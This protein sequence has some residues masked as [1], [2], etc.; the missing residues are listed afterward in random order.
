MRGAPSW[1]VPVLL[2]ASLA[3]PSHAAPLTLERIMADPDWI[4]PP[5]ERPFWSLDGG[6]VL[7]SLK[8]AGSPVRELW[9]APA[10]GG[11]SRRVGPTELAGLDAAQPVF[12]RTRQR[13]AFLRNGDVFV[14]DLKTR[15]L[16]Q[17]TR[18][19]A[20]ESSPQFAADGRS[21]QFRS[22]NDWLAYDLAS[23]VTGPV[24]LLALGK[25][26]DEKKPG[27]LERMQLRLIATLQHDRA[28]RDS[29]KREAERLRQSDPT[30]SPLPIYMG[31]DVALERSALSP[32]GRWLLV[33]TTPKGYD[34]GR[35]GK[36]PVY[37]TE[38]GYEESEEERT[39]VG[40][41][42]PAPQTLWLVDLQKRSREK[43]AY[44]PLPGIQDDLLASVRAENERAAG[45]KAPARSA[46]P[47]ADS[48]RAG[49]DPPKAE[50]KDRPLEVSAIA[51]NAQ[52]SE[53]LVRLTA[54]DNKDRWLATVD[55][56]KHVLRP[57]H[58]LTDSA[59]VNWD[60]NQAG[61]LPDGKKFWFLSEE[62]GYSHLYA[63]SPGAKAVALTSGTFEVS[64]PV[65]APDG[66]WIYALTNAE[67]PYAYDVYRVPTS[68]GAPGHGERLTRL[69]GCSEF[70]LSPDGTRL[71]VLHSSTHTPSQLA[72]VSAGPP[73]QG[74]SGARELTDTRT[75]EYKAI[76]WPEPRIVA[77]P[78][79]HG[80]TPIW[81]RLYLPADTTGVHPIVMFVHGAGYLQNTQLQF[82]YY[83]R[84]QMF[85]HLLNEH[86]YIV[87]DM[88]YRASQGYGRDWRT[89]IYRRMGTPELEDL[90]D[91]V[92]WLAKEH[93]GDEKHVGVYGGSYGG[94]MALMAMFRAPDVFR[95]GAALRPVTDWAQYNH[96]YT[97]AILNT[98]QVDSLAYARSSPIEY[99]AGLKGA[100]LIC[101]GVI[102]DNVLFEDSV[103]L[104]QRLI[105][106]HK[107]DVTLAPFPMERHGF[108][109]ADSW[110]DEYKRIDALFERT[111]R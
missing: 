29:L 57:E 14:R 95:A 98:P 17:V 2:A 20:N 86:G 103:R 49:T 16:T 48:G 53:A 93:G 40:R 62:S 107:D 43:L 67:A 66:R 82:P 58:R 32:G 110:L 34:E 105:E 92:H 37:V 55:F 19:P 68:G 21:L 24:A 75:A 50:H 27:D 52:G 26:P 13:A 38:S 64:A 99:A 71:W 83:F 60:Y 28:D 22:G 91:G 31:D 88:D 101:H 46:A 25:D 4:G 104:Y 36:L 33:V 11:A 94:F 63:K 51:F 102:D 10:G 111:L 56:D 18:T 72:T 9:R 100:L 70:G 87:L 90:I 79:S 81:S 96:G 106:L 12:D 1:L 97:A 65:V 41:N 89:A 23:G 44:T 78:S 7:Y 59:W 80:S 39:R 42:D 35:V 6:S 47:T 8:R 73:A 109:H 30:R 69:Q 45:T 74:G 5:V 84:E 61:W 85:H 108:V 15:K 3:A 76:H 77:V 54:N